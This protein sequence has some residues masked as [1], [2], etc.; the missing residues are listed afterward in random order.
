MTMLPD[1][2]VTH[3]RRAFDRDPSTAML[4]ALLEE[5][6]EAGQESAYD[7]DEWRVCFWIN[8]SHPDS[9]VHM[10]GVYGAADDRVDAELD[11]KDA[12]A[13]AVY[14][15]PWI[16]HRRAGE[17]PWVRLPEVGES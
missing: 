3:C 15:E 5:A 1:D 13:A 7:R 8:R 16:E 14:D 10:V 2:F 11:L 9:A 12:L 17:T 6:F 4:I